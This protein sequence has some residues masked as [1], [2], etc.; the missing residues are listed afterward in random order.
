MKVSIFALLEHVAALLYVAC[1]I[2]EKDICIED[3]NISRY[4]EE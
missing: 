1:A 3:E 2:Y 4:I